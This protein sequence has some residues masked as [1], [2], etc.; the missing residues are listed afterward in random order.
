MKRWAIAIGINQYHLFQPLSFAQQDAQAIR[1]FWVNEAGFSPDQCLLLTD[2]SLPLWGKPTYP[3]REVIQGWL[4]WL[5]QHSIQPGDSLWVFF[6]GY[7]VQ[8]QGRDYLVPIDANPANLEATSIPVEAIFN[9]LKLA[10]AE[11]V[12]VLLDMSRSQSSLPNEAVGSQTAELA[13]HF[14]IPTVLSC[15]PGQFSHESPTLK[16]GFFT[17]ALLEGFRSH[18]FIT[19]TGLEQFLGDRLTELSYQ[20]WRPVQRSLLVS[21]TETLGQMV[22]PP[23]GAP[24]VGWSF[25]SSQTNALQRQ[26]PETALTP[27]GTAA[28]DQRTILTNISTPHL[29]PNLNFN[30]SLGQ[31]S[32]DP[33]A[34]AVDNTLQNTGDSAP[35]ASETTPEGESRATDVDEIPGRSPLFWGGVTAASLLLI[36]G[37]CSRHWV[38]MTQGAAQR[39]SVAIA[40]GSGI[41]SNGGSPTQGTS[42]SQ[43]AAAS[44]RASTGQPTIVASAPSLAT[45]AI[46]SPSGAAPASGTG[47]AGSGKQAP[48]A[49]MS[50]AQSPAI[51]NGMT[52]QPGLSSTQ[53]LGRG[54]AVTVPGSNP[55]L[56]QSPLDIARSR[57]S[58]VVNSDQASPY[59][60]AIQE[61]RK[62]APEDPDYSQAQQAIAEWSESIFAIANRRADQRRFET[63]IMAV[64][65]VP[66]NQPI[67]PKAEQALDRWCLSLVNQ[68]IRNRPLR[69]QANTTCQ[70]L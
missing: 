18:P 28:P 59:W 1:N 69:R 35:S 51:S 55:A 23:L 38:S 65:L 58:K 42:Q 50:A 36:T 67:S 39:S 54:V 30:R 29:N 8:I 3:G 6:S 24:T 25:T 60:Y 56:Y 40:T 17:A 64:A 32:V 31:K 45:N 12:L 33:A 14:G 66:E 62:I 16:Q 48:G 27:S 4:D 63:A 44:L 7:G 37:V 41:P 11:S 10:Q 21:P 49:S 5:C 57:V 34:Q 53:R 61:A 22:L 20:N 15:L 46:A 9:R 26:V 43:P 70:Q 68:P 47:S 13:K 2:V 52:A 19:L